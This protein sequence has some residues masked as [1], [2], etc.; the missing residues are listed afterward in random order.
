MRDRRVFWIVALVSV[1]ISGIEIGIP[2]Y[3]GLY[4]SGV[5]LANAG[6]L[7]IGHLPY[8][9]YWSVQPPGSVLLFAPLGV[10]ARF[11]GYHSAFV[12]SRWFEAALTA[13]AAVSASMLVRRSSWVVMLVA[14]VGFAVL[15]VTQTV[16]TNLKL[17]PATLLLC[18]L[19]ADQL[20]NR[21]R[22][23]R[24]GV[25]FGL[26]AS[27]KLWA[28]FP[29]L[30]AVLV[31]VRHRRRVVPLVL[32]AGGALAVVCLPFV[33]AAPVAFWRGVFVDQFN[34]RAL[35]SEMMPLLDRFDFLNGLMQASAVL[36]AV[37]LLALVVR[38][39][40]L[41]RGGEVFEVE[42]FALWSFLISAGALMLSAECYDYYFVFPGM[43][44]VIVAALSI[45]AAAWQ[46]SVRFALLWIVALV[47]VQ[48]LA[49]YSAASSVGGF[50]SGA[51]GALG[52]HVAPDSCVVY[53]MIAEGELTDRMPFGSRCPVI[54]D[55]YGTWMQAGYHVTTPP[56]WFVSQSIGEFSGASYAV[57]PTWNNLNWPWRSR[58]FRVFMRSSFRVVYRGPAG[59]VWRNVA[60]A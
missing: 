29:F 22:S 28:F 37:L 57:E 46:R 13:G 53:S 51:F 60:G 24:A 19:A 36:S 27:V 44:L 58:R 52:S 10:V 42:R 43:F 17:E 50:S 12:L 18:L 54:T 45:N 9:D 47:A 21:Y 55:S 23:G 11:F 34:R 38:Y 14:G 20:F 30:A 4:D 5:Y 3:I 32:A 35:V 48:A 16:S 41:F 2:R 33:V 25:L 39:L 7:A 40:V 49:Y 26:A 8:R 56:S 6:Q 31:V 59:I 15:P 1:V